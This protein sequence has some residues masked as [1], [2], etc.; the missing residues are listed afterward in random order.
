MQPIR[1]PLVAFARS[2]ST[3]NLIRVLVADDHTI[4]R[5]GVISL[6]LRSGA[7][8]VVAEATNGL[9]AIE[10]ALETRPDVAVI[11]LAMP[12][13]NGVEVVRRIHTELPKTRILVLSMY[14][15][16]DHILQNMHAGADGYL[17]K[18]APTLE[19]VAAVK[20][21][22]SGKAYFAPEVAS[23]I[24]EQL[25]D[26]PAVGGDPYLD[27]TPREREVF[28]LIIQGKPTKEIAHDL[29]ISVK[30]AENHRTNLMEKLQVDNSVMLV[31]YAVNKGLFY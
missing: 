4:V 1:D 30:T 21:L 12:R 15:D 23:M 5:E 18:S 31:R 28:H 27:L 14:S 24:A 20:A 8:D 29:N 3:P 11:D 16:R 25:R 17:V 13:L 19:L 7:C 22:H 2:L 9:E 6:L 10:L 26:R